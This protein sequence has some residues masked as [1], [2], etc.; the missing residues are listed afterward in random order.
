MTKLLHQ[1]PPKDPTAMQFTLKAS[2]AKEFGRI[3][4]KINR[5]ADHTLLAIRNSKIKQPLTDTGVYIEA[6][7][8]NLIGPGI[9]VS[10]ILTNTNLKKIKRL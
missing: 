10:F 9:T 8:T 7:L 6:D 4:E 3:L 5:F 2:A 1:Y